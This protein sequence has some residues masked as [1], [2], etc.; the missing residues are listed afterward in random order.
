MAA[1]GC[2]PIFKSGFFRFAII[3]RSSFALPSAQIIHA[4]SAKVEMGPLLG[5]AS[6]SVFGCELEDRVGLSMVTDAGI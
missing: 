3:F 6:L 5:A 1:P 2:V 4:R